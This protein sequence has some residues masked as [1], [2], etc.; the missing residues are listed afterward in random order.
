M[1]ITE[2]I[3]SYLSASASSP[4]GQT[5]SDFAALTWTDV[6]NL[7]E[8]PEHGPA[9][10]VVNFTDIKTGIVNKLHGELNYGSLSIPM[11]YDA[12][13][14]GQDILRAAL[15]SKDEISFR[16]T[17]SDASVYYVM[18]KVTS[19]TRSANAGAVFGGT[20]QIEFTNAIVEA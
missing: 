12:S 6:G 3:G 9:H 13:D 16:I 2:G 19:F 5:V 17:V 15:T 11:G 4:A 18:G 8:I 10:A 14:A 1:A 20:C 7:T